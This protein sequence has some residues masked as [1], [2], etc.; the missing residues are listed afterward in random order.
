MGRE[1]DERCVR[2]VTRFLE[3]A[4]RVDLTLDLS[5]KAADEDDAVVAVSD[6]IKQGFVGGIGVYGRVSAR[7]RVGGVLLAVLLEHFGQDLPNVG[8]ADKAI[9][10]EEDFAPFLY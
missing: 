10:E 4:E 1:D 3:N 5:V 9:A 7:D 8:G 2:R 6:L